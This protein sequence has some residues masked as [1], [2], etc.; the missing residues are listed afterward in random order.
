EPQGGAE[1]PRLGRPVLRRQGAVA[2]S[3]ADDRAL[4]RAQR[5][6][7][8]RRPGALSV[9]LIPGCDR[10]ATVLAV[11][12]EGNGSRAVRLGGGRSASAPRVHRR[13]ARAGGAW[14]RRR[15]EGRRGQPRATLGRGGDGGFVDVVAGEVVELSAEEVAGRARLGAR[16]RKLLAAEADGELAC[17]LDRTDGATEPIREPAAQ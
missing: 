3:S 14:R 12:R 11:H 9:E 6:R 2:E 16:A 15:E 5:E 13:G 17:R 4:H 8:G 1:G 7:Q 10:N